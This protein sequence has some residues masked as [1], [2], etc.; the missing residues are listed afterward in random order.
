VNTLVKV[1]R[2]VLSNHEVTN[3][4]QSVSLN[5]LNQYNS[6]DNIDQK[7]LKSL[8]N[9]E[10]RKKLWVLTNIRPASTDCHWAVYPNSIYEQGMLTA[11]REAVDF[12]SKTMPNLN[13]RKSPLDLLEYCLSQTRVDGLIC[14]FGVYSGIT[15]NHIAGLVPDKDV[16]G[17][18]SFEGLPENWGP[19]P[20]GLFSTKGELPAVKDNV[21]LHVGFFAETLP[22]F[23]SEHRLPVSFVHIDS[24]LYSSAKT[25]LDTLSSRIVAGS[26][27]VFDEFF[28]YPEWQ[29]HEYKAF[30]EFVS[31]FNVDYEY[32]AYTDRG[33]SVGILIKNI[34]R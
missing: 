23:I 14:E 2:I 6:Q 22:E 33:Y 24:D 21:Q 20:K 5:A 19:A 30:M 9:E 32:I 12:V 1:V 15:V 18:D 3:Y 17:F 34:D 25:I 27:L 8:D 26:I 13:G 29:D 7:L 31:D 28:N 16:H 10:V 11:T 4:F